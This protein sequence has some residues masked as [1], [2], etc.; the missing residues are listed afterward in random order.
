MEARTLKLKPW[1]LALAVVA[2]NVG[3]A[4]EKQAEPAPSTAVAPPTVDCTRTDCT[5]TGTP[6]A[7]T[8]PAGSNGNG[9]FYSGSTANFVPASGMLGQMFF[10]SYPNQPTQVQINIDLARS[11]DKIII[12]Y[13]ES[14]KVV[15]AAFDTKHPLNGYENSSLNQQMNRWYTIGGKLVYKSL[16]QDKYGAVMLIIDKTS[17]DGDGGLGPTVGG[18]I[19]FQN[20]GDNPSPEHTSATP[21][22]LNPYYSQ[23]WVNYGMDNPVECYWRQVKQKMCWEITLG[24]YDCRTNYSST[25][26]KG[27]VDL[28]SSLLPTNRGRSR[29]QSYQKLGYFTGLSRVESHLPTP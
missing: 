14:G 27:P 16:M 20:F 22:C 21:I 7:P 29:K 11:R 2:L 1:I 23:Y 6:G 19:W 10:N 4:Q 8:A 15:E 24:P 5:G 28:G 18:E 26:E 25:D 9:T 17:L 12:S 3:C 13:T